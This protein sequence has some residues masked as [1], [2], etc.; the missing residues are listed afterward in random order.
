MNIRSINI[1]TIN[2]FIFILINLKIIKKVLLIYRYY[3]NH[4][5]WFYHSIIHTYNLTFYNYFCQNQILNK[6]LCYIYNSGFIQDFNDKHSLNVSLKSNIPVTNYLVDFINKNYSNKFTKYKYTLDFFN[7]LNLNINYCISDDNNKIYS[8][9]FGRKIQFTIDNIEYKSYYSDY[10]CVDRDYRRKGLFNSLFRYALSKSIDKE[11]KVFLFKRDFYPLPIK[12]LIMYTY[13]ELV[14]FSSDIINTF[15]LK[16]TNN[17]INLTRKL[18]NF[19]ITNLENKRVYNKLSFKEFVNYISNPYNTFYY[20]INHPNKNNNYIEI[21]G[22][23][24]I[25]KTHIYYGGKQN[26]EIIFTIG[27]VEDI[28]L[29]IYSMNNLIIFSSLNNNKSILSYKSIKYKK[30][31]DCYYYLYNF[32]NREIKEEEVFLFI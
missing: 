26:T 31:S 18:Y 22:C 1:K 27:Y 32:N 3:L 21:N 14:D 24:L 5:F 29:K 13:Y 17:N 15:I 4:P 10:L 12:H 19:Y 8:I 28:L 16:W 11:T 9:G 30:L 7:N 20:T 25:N 2:N 23:I 6:E